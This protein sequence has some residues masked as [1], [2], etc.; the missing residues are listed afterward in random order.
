[1]NH[2]LT[3]DE[4]FSLATLIKRQ[5]NC[6]YDL[7]NLEFSMDLSKNKNH[8]I[9]KSSLCLSY[10]KI[11]Q[12]SSL[13]LAENIANIFNQTYDK[14][15]IFIKISHNSWLEFI[16]GDRL[17]NKWLNEIDKIKLLSSKNINQI[18]DENQ[19]IFTIIYTHARCC[20]IL[21]SAHQHKIISLNNLEFLPNQW[22]IEKPS[23]INYEVLSL[24]ASY[25]QKLI[26]EL[27]IITEK[28]ANNKLNYQ[29]S[30]NNLNKVILDLECHCRIWGET[31]LKNLEISQGRLGLIA[32]ALHYYQNLFYLQFNQYLPIE[33]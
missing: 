14:Y 13:D 31:K 15:D 3:L 28:I 19:D 21:T 16:I 33:I 20:S 24:S 4:S 29:T 22:Y 30:L 11:H 2:L 10:G 7:S 8:I 6:L 25:E 17:L 23:I 26:Q 27:I 1:M 32:I 12:K 9:Y 5:L 18:N